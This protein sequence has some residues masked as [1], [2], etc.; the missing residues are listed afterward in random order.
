MTGSDEVR[1]DLVSYDHD[2]VL[3]KD[4]HRFFDFAALPYTSAWVVR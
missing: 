4:L 1:P 2:V 3:L